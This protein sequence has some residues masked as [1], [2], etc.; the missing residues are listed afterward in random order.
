MTNT[1]T[2]TKTD[3]G[4]LIANVTSRELQYFSS[5]NVKGGTFRMKAE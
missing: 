1:Y 2:I 4:G 3:H 5:F